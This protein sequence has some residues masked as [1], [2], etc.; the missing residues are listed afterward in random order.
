MRQ[1]E[2]QNRR[3]SYVVVIDAATRSDR[4]LR[5]LANYLSTIGTAGCEVI[6]FDC[7]PRLQFD[8]NRRV[9]RW[10]SRHVAIRREHCSRGGTID[11]IRAA[12]LVAGC[13]KVVVAD[14]GVRYT[15]ESIARV[16]ELL[17]RHEVV[18]PQDYLDP[19]PWWNGV[20]AGR[21]LMHRAIDPQPDHGATFGFRRSIVHTL[22]ALG[23]GDIPGD[24]VRRLAA[25]GAEVYAPANVFVRRESTKLREWLAAR[26]RA[27]ADDFSLPTKNVFFFSLLP[28]LA[29]LTIL[30]SGRL[31]ASYAGV[32]AFASVGL[33]IRGRFGATAF[34]PLSA[35]LFAP[36]W[37]FERSVSVYW[38]LAR[39]LRGTDVDGARVAV[40]EGERG[41][42]IAG[43]RG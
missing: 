12:A 7:S 37:V 34:F 15:E 16:C 25:A 28:I 39:K 13:E 38:A 24:Q 35:S 33:A 5:E 17:D 43:G 22:P 42:R 36:V 20:E 29:I 11:P 19:L 32:I 1:G 23:S 26:P 6:V 2:R 40:H 27:A 10:V 4:A 3:C 31:A 14:E 18:E 8:L 21:I 30:G 41:E 9:L